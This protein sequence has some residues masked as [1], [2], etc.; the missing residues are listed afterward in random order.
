M[1]VPPGRT[2]FRSRHDSGIVDR[3]RSCDRRGARSRHRVSS[4]SRA[5]AGRGSTRRESPCQG[6]IDAYARSTERRHP[7]ATEPGEGRPARAVGRNDR[8][9]AGRAGCTPAGAD[10]QVVRSGP[11]R[12]GP[13]RV[14]VRPGPA[15]LSTPRAGVSTGHMGVPPGWTG[16]RADRV[17]S[18]R[19]PGGRADEG[20]PA[21]PRVVVTSHPPS[22]VNEA[23]T[24]TDR[25]RNDDGRTAW[26]RRGRRRPGGGPV[27]RAG[28]PV[29][30]VRCGP[31]VSGVGR[32]P[33]RAHPR[34]RR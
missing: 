29:C 10:H 30:V 2:G 26:T 19:G 25:R 23:L 17:R 18:G 11:V 4:E 32:R 15:R 9:R 7:P 16:S 8:D 27:A 1:A 3:V 5:A 31:R 22:R 28:G 21:A 33:G 34:R 14:R 6:I 12:S 24:P 20:S 13:V